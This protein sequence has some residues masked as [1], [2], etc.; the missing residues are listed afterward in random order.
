MDVKKN[1]QLD[2]VSETMGELFDA[3][4]TTAIVD[5]NLS[6]LEGAKKDPETWF[7]MQESNLAK[8]RKN[9]FKKMQESKEE[10]NKALDNAKDI[11]KID[12]KMAKRNTTKSTEALAIATAKY[13]QD[14]IRQ[15]Y[16]LSKTQPLF[17]SIFKQTQKGIANGLKVKVGGKNWGY[18]E[19]MEMNVRTTIQN[20]IAEQQLK[21]GEVV[22]QIFYLCNIFGD[23]RDAHADLQGRYYYDS[24]YKSFIDA[25]DTETL[26]AVEE[27][28]S[29]YGMMSVQEVQGAPY[30][31]VTGANCRH[32]LI[33]VSLEEVVTIKPKELAEKEKIVFGSYKKGQYDKTQEQR[34][35]ERNIRNYAKRLEQNKL[36][37][38]KEPNEV[39]KK[40]MDFDK[41]LLNKWRRKQRDL[42]DSNSKGKYD[43]ADKW[44]LE[45]DY[46]RETRNILLND[47][48]VKYR[49]PK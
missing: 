16:Q 2:A 33:P 9:I 4:E 28:I 7:K 19:Y 22:G 43:P 35:N 25:K 31:L 36:L 39:I 29:N 46:R 42:I 12:P 41:A 6:L 18:K 32:D 30:Y 20:E 34:Y 15:I 14:S 11:F 13:Y 3:T 27:A 37:Y 49:L 48:G 44:G 17:D 21:L 8:F 40:Q 45:R 5:A 47:L 38:Q 1:K 10:L 24:R 23:S 26:D